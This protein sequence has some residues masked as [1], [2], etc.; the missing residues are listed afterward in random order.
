MGFY[1]HNWLSCLTE[2]VLQCLFLSK[3][4]HVANCINSRFSDCFLAYVSR[5][6]SMVREIIGFVGCQLQWDLGTRIQKSAEGRWRS[7]SEGRATP[8]A[9]V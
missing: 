9:A 5:K 2:R 8:P 3:N 7:N 4:V 6:L 1:K